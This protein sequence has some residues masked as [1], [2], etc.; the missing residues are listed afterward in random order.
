MWDNNNEDTCIG[1][2]DDH[3][4]IVAVTAAEAA[5][6]R[7]KAVGIDAAAMLAAEVAEAA[8]APPMEVRTCRRC[9]KVVRK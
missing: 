9:G 8:K 2:R 1:Y 7:L 3:G 5:A 6:E 4:I